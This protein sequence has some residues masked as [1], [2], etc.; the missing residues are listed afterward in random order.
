MSAKLVGSVFIATLLLVATWAFAL[1]CKPPLEVA[2]LGP[3]DTEEGLAGD[4]DD[5]EEEEDDDDVEEGI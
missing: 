5:D 3:N 2:G 4:V 1:T